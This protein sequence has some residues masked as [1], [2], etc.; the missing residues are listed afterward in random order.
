[1][2]TRLSGG[3]TPANGADPRTFPAIWNATAVDIEAVEADVVVL[4]SDVDVVEGSAVA[5]GSAVTVLQGSAVALG[6]AVDVIEAWDLEDLNDVT[7]TSPTEAQ[8]LA[9]ST[10]VSGWVNADAA[11]G[12]S[13]ILYNG[14]MQVAQRGTSF[15]A[16]ANNDDVY[17][18]DRWNLLSDGN[19]A[20]DVTQSTDGPERFAY[21]IALDVET[22]N[23]KFG[24][25]QF[26]E[27]K[28]SIQ[29]ENQTVTLSFYAKVTGSSISDVKA[30]V[31]SWSS[32]A[33]SVTSDV[34]SSW[35]ASGT[36]PTFAANWTAENTPTNLNV[37]TS[38]A[39]YS[40]TAT[41]DTA[42]MANV[43]VFIWND[44]ATTTLGDFLYIT[45]VQLEA[46][47]VA[48]PF[49]HKPY[50]VEL[51]E[52][53]RYYYKYR[54]TGEHIVN[55]LVS[56]AAQKVMNSDYPLPMRAT[57]TVTTYDNTG[58]SGKINTL[59]S[60]GTSTPGV[61]PA[62]VQQNEKTARVFIVTT[63]TGFSFSLEA[64]AEL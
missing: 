10:A 41:V 50:G 39:R 14:A 20:V 64:D 13:N 7:V 54:S 6:S 19:D 33:D 21:S 48:T 11:G 5:L 27:N 38:W 57:P 44:D 9:Y 36:V 31:L 51:A 62:L 35:N 24:I 60:N 37:T 43:A 40:V 59:I 28:D 47:T 52:C 12:V 1:M 16:S 45:G 58:A 42:S 29:L 49:E 56:T 8:V 53:W 55:G 23:K 22:A 3:L 4:Q 2:V 17:T 61:T 34:V 32:T 26:L 46:G 30:A 15:T 18:L 25:A 63:P